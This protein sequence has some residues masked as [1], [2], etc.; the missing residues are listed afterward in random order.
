[1]MK[2]ATV[3]VLSAM[4][5]LSS[6]KNVELDSGQIDLSLRGNF[7][8]TEVTKSQVSDYTSLP[9]A[10][11]F[12]VTLKDSKSA[13]VWSGQFSEFD[14]SMTLPSGS[15]SAEAVFGAEGR[16]GFDMPWMSG[17]TG[18]NVMVGQVTSVSVPVKLCNSIVR[19]ACTDSFKDYFPDYSFKVTTGS[20]TVIQFPKGENRGAFIDAYRF[21]IDGTMTNAAG[22][23]KTF[24]K[25]YSSGIEAATCYTVRFDVSNIGKLMVTVSFNDTLETVELGDVELND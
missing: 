6:C 18:F 14:P 24:T 8:I 25:E 22:Y 12:K 20:N 3:L 17:S 4:A 13:T 19:V 5:I 2:K 10:S 15:Y 21:K 7:D 9:A 23:V 11:D 1:M 16:E